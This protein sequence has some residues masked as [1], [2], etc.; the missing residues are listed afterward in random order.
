MFR[1][2]DADSSGEIHLSELLEFIDGDELGDAAAGAT[3][4]E[5]NRAALDAAAGAAPLLKTGSQR[6]S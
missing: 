5:R 6:P 3:A 1:Y 2:I 4:R